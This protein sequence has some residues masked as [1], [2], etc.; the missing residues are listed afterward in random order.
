MRLGFQS[1]AVQEL[2]S[3]TGQEG[4]ATLVPTTPVYEGGTSGL[5]ICRLYH[6]PL[7]K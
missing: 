1:Q 3:L 2:L 6:M 7:G 4:V 5:T